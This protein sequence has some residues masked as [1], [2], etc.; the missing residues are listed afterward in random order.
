M[1]PQ[2]FHGSH[3]QHVP[4]QLFGPRRS[5][6]GHDPELWLFRP[7]SDLRTPGAATPR[8]TG[9][10]DGDLSSDAQRNGTAQQQR[11]A[12]MAEHD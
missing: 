2:V 3:F 1:V 10:A 11:P 7:G 6:E 4:P 8:C 12:K 9:G 5:Q